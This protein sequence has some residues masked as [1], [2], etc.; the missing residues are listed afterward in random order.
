MKNKNYVFITGNQFAKILSILPINKKVFFTLHD[1]YEVSLGEEPE[2]WFCAKRIKLF[3]E[4]NGV[5]TIGYMGGG[6]TV[7]YDDVYNELTRKQS[8]DLIADYLEDYLLAEF[9]ANMD[10]EHITIEITDENRDIINKVLE[11]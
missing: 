10:K 4:T 9:V 11:E 1:A 6:H 8:E 5:L 3:D 2:G 7:V